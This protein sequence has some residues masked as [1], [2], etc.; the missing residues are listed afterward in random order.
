MFV[1]IREPSGEL[2]INGK[3]SQFIHL[4]W[5]RG[6]QQRQYLYRIALEKLLRLLA[7]KGGVRLARLRGPWVGLC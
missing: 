7:G 6:L 1:K 2:G 3:D 4:S 5:W